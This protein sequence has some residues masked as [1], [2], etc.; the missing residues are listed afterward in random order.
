MEQKFCQSCAMPLG[1]NEEQYGTEKNGAHNHDYC[2]Y[3][4]KDGAFAQDCTMQEMID[5]CAPIMAQN[6][7]GMTEDKAREAMNQFFPML[8]RWA[9]A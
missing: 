5:F 2:S 8:K 9:K 6:S 7:P 3:C 1:D 4:Y